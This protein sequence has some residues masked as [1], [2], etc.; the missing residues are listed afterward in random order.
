MNIC[1]VYSF[2]P[3]YLVNTFTR[4]FPSFYT[5]RLNSAY[6]KLTATAASQQKNPGMAV[7]QNL[8]SIPSGESV[9]DD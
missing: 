1:L 5:L 7:E 3:F 8:K 6:N 9:A 4:F 2:Y